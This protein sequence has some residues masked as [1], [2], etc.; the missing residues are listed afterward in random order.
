M[1]NDFHDCR[2]LEVSN[3]RCTLAAD[4]Y[5]PPFFLEW[6]WPS[7]DGYFIN[8]VAGTDYLGMTAAMTQVPT[9][10][11]TAPMTQNLPMTTDYDYFL[12]KSIRP[13]TKKR[14]PR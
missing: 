4:Y 2:H 10:I 6:T 13:D 12:T 3:K 9:A 1:T 14:K 5:A 11:M 8:V 7:E